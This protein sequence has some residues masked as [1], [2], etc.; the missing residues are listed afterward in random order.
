V[1][2]LENS[3]LLDCIADFN[4]R[5]ATSW[6]LLKVAIFCV[7]TLFRSFLLVSV[8]W[9]ATLCLQSA[10]VSKNT[11]ATCPHSW[12]GI[13]AAASWPRHGNLLLWTVGWSHVRSDERHRSLTVSWVLCAGALSCWKTN[14]SP[15]MLLHQQHVSIALSVDFRPGS[16]KIRLVKGVSISQLK[17][18]QRY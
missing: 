12:L 9:S 15:V 8:V 10:H 1:D 2:S 5:Q 18:L 6:K 11:D 17:T 16:T 14:T 3:Q 13:H 7:D 4:F